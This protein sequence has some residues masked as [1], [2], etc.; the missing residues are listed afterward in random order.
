MKKM[1][2]FSLIATIFIGVSVACSQSD[3]DNIISFAS[4]PTEVKTTVDNDF[5]GLEIAYIKTNGAFG[6]YEVKFTNGM[7]VEFNSNGEWREIECERGGVPA[8]YIPEAINAFVELNYPGAVIEKISRERISYEVE[9][10]NDVEIEFDMEFNVI[11]IDDDRPLNA[12]S[13][14]AE[15]KAFIESHFSTLKVVEVELDYERGEK[16]Y[17]IEFS[18]GTDLEIGANGEWREIDVERGGVPSE[19]I[20]TAIR[21]YVEQNYPTALIEKISRNPR[22]YEIELN[23]DLEIKFDMEFNVVEIDS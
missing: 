4:L 9:L 7:E 19:L 6:E 10:N 20:P 18:D 21:T 1:T 13:L 11:D 12:N 22:I 2:L 14:P 3:D 23:N 16:G 5:G 17:K 8:E 15:V